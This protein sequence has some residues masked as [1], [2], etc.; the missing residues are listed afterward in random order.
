M[1]RMCA[2]TLESALLTF[3]NAEAG[4]EE[5]EFYRCVGPGVYIGLAAEYADD[6]VQGR[7]RRYVL[8]VKEE[9]AVDQ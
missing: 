2:D 4:T 7:K 3:S 8:L 9:T 6:G 1:R 5:R